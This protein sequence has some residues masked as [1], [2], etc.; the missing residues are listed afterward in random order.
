MRSGFESSAMMH[1]AG[2]GDLSA[3]RLAARNGSPD[4]AKEAAV[5][6]EALFIQ[7]MLGEMRRSQSFGGG[8]FDSAQ[9][10][11][12]HQMFDQRIAEQMSRAGGIGLAES[13]QD[14]LGITSGAAGNPDRDLMIPSRPPAAG[15]A[16][17][18]GDIDPAQQARLA[19][20]IATGVVPLD[21]YLAEDESPDLLDEIEAGH[22]GIAAGPVE[23]PPA[24]PDAFVDALLPHAQRAGERLGV[25]PEVL[26]AQAALETGW[27]QHMMPGP[28]GGPGYNLFGVKTG[29]DWQGARVNVQTLEYRDGIARRERAEFRAY[30][31]LAESFEDYASLLERLPRYRGALD[32][33]ADPRGFLDGLQ[34]GGY[35]TDPRYAD[36]IMGIVERGLPG[37]GGPGGMGDTI[38]AQGQPA[39]PERG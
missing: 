8:L 27:G 25:A 33:A 11:L 17:A 10:D 31:G 9:S 20:A 34:Q 16:G 7:M 38:T 21:D 14:S 6:F 36:K 32:N 19:A 26:V 39:R 3:L 37:L 22:D 15:R 18:A 4:A 23:W 29:G 1:R 30:D 13:L 12:Y 2:E 35:A 24:T 5:Q 28:N